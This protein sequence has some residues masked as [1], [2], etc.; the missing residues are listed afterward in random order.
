[1]LKRVLGVGPSNPRLILLGEAAGEEEEA[2]GVPFVG[3]SGSYLNSILASAGVRREDCYLTNVVK[4]RPPNNKL[5]RLEELG[6]SIEEFLPELK[7]ELS[8]I[9]CNVILS[10]GE[11]ATNFSCGETEI[12]KKRGSVY[13]SIGIIGEGRL[14]VPT[15]HPRFIIEQYKMKGVV[16]EDVRKGLRIRKEG[17]NEPTF[18]TLLHPTLPEVESYLQ[19]LQSVDRFSFDIEVV[20]SGQIACLGIG[21]GGEQTGRSSICIPFKFGFNNYWNPFEEWHIWDL[22]RKVFQ[23]DHLKIG[24]NLNYDLSKLLPFIGEPS[25]PW[26]DLMMA[27]HLVEADL[28]HS[29]GFMTSLYTWPPVNYYK[30]DPKDEEKSWKYTTSS[31]RLWEYNGKDCEVPLM[32]EERL[33]QELKEMGMLDFFYG[34]M[35]SKMRVH[36]RIQQRGLLLDEEKR[37]ELLSKQVKELEEKQKILDEAVGYHLN[38]SSGPQMI[39]FLYEELKLPIQRHRKTK[40]ATADEEALN[41]LIV[42]HPHPALQL[43]INMRE[44][45]HDIGTYLM[46]EA[47]GDGRVRGRYNSA[48]A[49]TGRSS[50]KKGYEGRGLDLHNIPEED[51]QMFIAREGCSFV[52]RDL[53]QAETYGVAVLSQCQTFLRRLEDG[54]KI[55]KLVA[56][57]LFNKPESE[58]DSNNRPGGEY[59]TGKRVGH[60]LNYGLGPILLAINLKCSVAEAKRYIAVYFSSAPEIVNWHKEIE[61]EVKRTRI[62]TTPLGR[63]R[64]FRDRMGDDLFRKAYAHIPQSLIAEYNHLGMIKLEYLLPPGAEILQEGYDALLV[65]VPDGLIDRVKSIMEAAFDKKIFAKGMYFKIPGEY[66]INRRWV[67]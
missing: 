2:Q 65:E 24:Q 7:E 67:K 44:L 48:G 28:P 49:A 57:W 54:K 47:E 27:H 3:A 25:P 18:R 62:L 60:G 42:F 66:S 46:V 34:F 1:M 16:I 56:S 59:Y 10:L 6:V 9:N 29:L 20:G 52:E 61:E 51:R 55:H 37:A 39:K 4:V 43:A 30:D 45:R 36:W 22:I 50:S 14:I 35:M 40:K 33:T 26:Y 19:Q 5:E 21:M 31:E 12:S 38:P 23:G 64:I 63:K 41:K 53:W 15:Y 11:T 32:I 13:P 17:Y 8:K 58:V